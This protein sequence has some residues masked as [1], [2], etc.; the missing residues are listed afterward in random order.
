MD[1]FS[2]W[3]LTLPT[4]ARCI[5]T[6]NLHNALR[7]NKGDVVTVTALYDVDTKSTRSAPFPG[8]DRTQNDPVV[9]ALP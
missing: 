6:E 2:C 8:E 4:T 3:E 1:D 9:H 7:L 5:D